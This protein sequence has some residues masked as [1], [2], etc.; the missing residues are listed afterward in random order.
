MNR[1]LAVSRTRAGWCLTLLLS[2]FV[3]T[4][5]AQAPV[6]V[7]TPTPAPAESPS[8]HL[9]LAQVQGIAFQ[10]NWDLLAA[11]SGID[12]A[13]AQL[14]VAKE[15][16]NPILSWS[17]LKIDPRGNGTPLGNSIWDRSYDT[18]VSINQLV[19]IGGKRHAR[20]NSARAGIAGARAR[21]LDA[22]R[23]LDQG[24]TK[25]YVAALL[26]DGNAHVLSE[27]SAALRREADIAETRFK[28][29]DISDS[30][31]KQIEN[32]ADVFELQAKSAEATAVQARIQ[33]EVLMGVK[34]P[35]GKWVA[36]DSLDKLGLDLSSSQHK[37][38]AGVRPDVLAAQEDLR[39]A[40]AEVRLQKSIRVPDPTFSLF[41]ERNPP[42]PPGPDT[43]GLGLSFPLPIWNRNRGNIRAAEAARQETEFALGKISSQAQADITAAEIGYQEARQRWQRYQEQIRPRSA[44]VR[45]SIAFAYSKGGASLVDLLTAERDDNNVRLAA[46]Q[47]LADAASAAVDLKA[48]RTV[49]SEAELNQTK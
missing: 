38:G 29:G 35:K 19:E 13:A 9:S 10:R 11:R 43:L 17:T 36:D 40:E 20:Q 47:A 49:T 32:N 37:S 48:A 46:A 18:I 6:N 23:S 26:A 5:A 14:I 8:L 34:E 1:F 15:F 12:S 30:D 4:G 45:E 3:L 31:R 24:V 22:R 44:Q 25:A 39:K 16:P 21:F 33:V 41:Y 7:P 2:E 42:G 28:A 27:S